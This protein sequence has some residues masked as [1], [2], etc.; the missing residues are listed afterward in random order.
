MA[1]AERITLTQDQIKE[2]NTIYQNERHSLLSG[3]PFHS[4][5]KM[6]KSEFDNLKNYYDGE[7]S[8]FSFLQQSRILM[9]CWRKDAYMR[10]HFG[11]PRCMF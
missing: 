4:D 3:E 11:L 9:A 2:Y 1:I 5:F 8:E 10:G 7:S 6:S